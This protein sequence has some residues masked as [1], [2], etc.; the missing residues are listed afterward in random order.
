MDV[1]FHNQL[2]YQAFAYGGRSGAGTV[3]SLSLPGGQDKN[4]KSIFHHFSCIFLLFFLNF[5]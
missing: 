5:S 4:I 3:A 2:R 1:Q